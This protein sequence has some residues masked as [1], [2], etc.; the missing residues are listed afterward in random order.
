M[1]EYVCAFQPENALRRGSKVMIRTLTLY[2]GADLWISTDT[3]KVLIPSHRETQTNWGFKNWLGGQA[4]LPIHTRMHFN[5]CV[6]SA[7][8]GLYPECSTLRRPWS[9][10][11]KVFVH[12]TIW[13]FFL[14]CHIP[15]PLTWLRTTIGLSFEWLS[16]WFKHFLLKE[17]ISREM[18]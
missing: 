17:A 4:R 5:A 10:L 11:L 14:D 15:Y 6:P 9:F 18:A 2:V 3:S 7:L 13:V 8:P 12:S 16:C 1:S